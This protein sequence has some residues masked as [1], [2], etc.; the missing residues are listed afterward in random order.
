MSPRA[1]VGPPC[2][3]AN[4][5]RLRYNT[6]APSAKQAAFLSLTNKECLFGGSAGSGKSYS[7]LLAALQFCD[8]PGYS[9]LLLRRTLADLKLPGSLIPMSREMLEGRATY[10]ANDY[11]WTFPSGAVIQFG[12]LQNPGDELRYQGSQLQFCVER[13]TRI[14]MS[15]GSTQPIHDV[16]PGDEVA[17]LEGPRRV[18]RSFH[19]GHKPSVR[20]TTAYGSVVC[21]DTHPILMS[22]GTWVAPRALIPTTPLPAASI[23]EVSQGSPREPLLPVGYSS[24]GQVLVDT[25]VQQRLDQGSP[26]GSAASVVDD[27]IGSAASGDS[28]RDARLLP[29]WFDLLVRQE[30]AAQSGEP[31]GWFGILQRVPDRDFG[32]P[33]LQGSQGSCDPCGRRC[34]ERPHAVPAIA[35]APLPSLAGAEAL[36]ERTPGGDPDCI[37]GRNPVGSTTFY[38]P[39]TM[40]PVE[41]TAVYEPHVGTR[42]VPVGDADLWDIQVEGA[43]H[44]ISSESGIVHMNCGF[45]ELTQFPDEDQY[46]YLFSRLRRPVMPREEMASFYGQSPDGLTLA[47]IPLRMRAATNP[48]G[49]GSA[50]TKKRFVDP[51]TA[52]APFLPARFYDNPAIPHEEYREALALLGEVQRRRLELGDWSVAEEEG[53]LWKFEDIDRV[54]EPPPFSVKIMAVDGSVGSGSG[55]E[56]G[57]VVGGIT[58]D[59]TVVVLE[60]LSMRGHPDDWSK[61]A[62]LGYHNHGCTRLV[63]EANQGGELN[64]I[65]LNNAADVLKASRPHILTP[66]A[67]AGESKERRAMPVAQAYRAGKVKH[68]PLMLDSGLEAQ[69]VAWVPGDKR[70]VP[71]PDRVD[72][73]VWMVRELLFKVTAGPAPRS[74]AKEQLSTWGRQQG[75]KTALG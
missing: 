52:K 29:E 13:T 72:A 66:R 3:T 42:M 11:K 35:P 75:R 28:L 46:L 33:A 45:D 69:M 54:E 24:S 6:A 70:S 36:P 30:L 56:C 8:V 61:R 4:G 65:A 12:Y 27:R 44:Y 10:N 67:N 43:S 64:R 49:P 9:A 60:D 37:P 1:E 19:V 50:W 23:P 7:L 48:G 18:L 16:R 39:Y 17:T 47:D 71:S 26:R 22:D 68:G 57:I 32:D 5:P 21:S 41:A 25:P 2:L 63:I 20:I 34:G 31:A 53:A 73:L 58:E 59:G 38:H 40:E 55:D 74:A 15:D 62:I 14:I 51:D